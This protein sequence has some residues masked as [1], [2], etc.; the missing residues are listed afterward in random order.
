MESRAFN[1]DQAASE[2]NYECNNPQIWVRTIDNNELLFKYFDATVKEEKDE[3]K[4][5]DELIFPKSSQTQKIKKFTSLKQ[6]IL[7]EA[8][9][10]E[11]DTPVYVMSKKQY[12]VIRK[13]LKNQAVIESV[14]SELYRVKDKTGSVV[15]NQQHSHQQQSGTQYEVRLST[16]LENVI[17]DSSDLKRVIA[18]NIRNH[19]SKG[20]EAQTIQIHVRCDS[21]IVQLLQY[22]AQIS[23]VPANFIN[24]YHK[25]KRLS[26]SDQLCKENIIDGDK[27]LCLQGQG[28]L[29]SFLR[30]KV[31][32]NSG[33]CQA[34]TNWEAITWRPNRSIMVA[35]F[36]TYGLTSGQQNFFVRYKYL[37]QNVA[38]EENV[39]EV[40]SSEIDDQTKIYPIMFEGDMLEVP[41][42]TDLTI[43]TRTYGANNNFRVRLYYGYNG[44]SYKSFD[45]TD[46]DL[47]EITASNLSSN[48]TSVDSGQIPSL[49]YYVVG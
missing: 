26:N 44:T 47:F 42:G 12:G 8:S 34:A 30:F 32:S 14:D 27:L 40:M 10:M 2:L 43:I 39:V 11:T 24:L 13:C 46:R 16:S 35:G 31:V 9:S 1:L 28:D 22:I 25:K 49:Y 21:S 15:I 20:G 4:I 5:K 37:L 38:S 7:K 45:N 33:W 19:S 41:A 36:G 17:V 18:L 48:G 23:Q 6:K 3:K 29:H